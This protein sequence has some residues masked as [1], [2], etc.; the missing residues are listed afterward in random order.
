MKV[1]HHIKVERSFFG[2]L[3]ELAKV[4]AFGKLIDAIVEDLEYEGQE[5]SECGN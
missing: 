2:L 1:I 5:V 3:V 4:A